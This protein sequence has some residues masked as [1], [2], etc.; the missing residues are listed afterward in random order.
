MKVSTFLHY[1][2]NQNFELPE[3]SRW[4]PDLSSTA[5]TNYF[6]SMGFKISNIVNNNLQISVLFC[7]EVD[8]KRNEL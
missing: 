5:V 4:L 8:I 1:L 7:S 3:F 6:P 2:A